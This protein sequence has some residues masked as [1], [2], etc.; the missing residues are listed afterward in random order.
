MAYKLMPFGVRRLSDGASIPPDPQNADW[1]I[2]QNW[3]ADGGVPVALDPDPLMRPQIKIL[4]L[5]ERNPITH[6]ELRELI[7][8]L[9]ELY[10]AAKTTPFYV[11]AKATD[12]A[13]KI[14]RAKL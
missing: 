8:A 12:D 4:Q 13:I 1:R 3:L 6:R 5:E 14:E 2:Y 10:P 11:R 7:L 9:G